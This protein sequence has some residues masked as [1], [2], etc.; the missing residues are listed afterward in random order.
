MAQAPLA[1]AAVFLWNTPHRAVT[2]GEGR[3]LIGD[4]PSGD[5]T[6]LFF[7]AKLGEMGISAGPRSVHVPSSDTVEVHLATPSTFTM[8]V[9]PCLLEDTGPGTGAIAGWVGD[10]ATGMSL[11]QAHV[12]LSWTPD[13]ASR[14]Q[15]LEL[16]RTRAG[17]IGRVP[18]RAACRSRP[19]RASSAGW[20]CIAR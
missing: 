13:G 9:A 12:E 5:Y 14:P 20:G 10:G 17:G 15:H 3:F 18:R 2:D 7:H 1:D 11:P 6:L 16:R 4:V 8:M 19:P